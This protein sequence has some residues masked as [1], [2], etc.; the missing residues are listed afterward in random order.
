MIDSLYIPETF[1]EAMHLD[2]L[3]VIH[4]LLAFFY[5]LFCL[6]PFSFG[7]AGMTLFGPMTFLDLLRGAVLRFPFQFPRAFAC[8]FFFRAAH[9]HFPPFLEALCRKTARNFSKLFRFLS[10]KGIQFRNNSSP[11]LVI[12]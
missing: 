9:V 7:N 1:A 4:V 11:S 12:R 8:G 5:L 3:P 2:D 6:F 10:I